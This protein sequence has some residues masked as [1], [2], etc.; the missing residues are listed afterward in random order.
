[1]SGEKRRF[2]GGKTDGSREKSTYKRNIIYFPMNTETKRKR[3]KNQKR[4]SS[5]R[6]GPIREGTILLGQSL[7]ESGDNFPWGRGERNRSND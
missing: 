1:L 5:L 7:F 6:G 4:K 3:R 2:W